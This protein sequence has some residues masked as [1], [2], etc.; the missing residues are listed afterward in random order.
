MV[1]DMYPGYDGPRPKM[2]IYHG[3]ADTTLHANN[4]E[5]TIKQWAGVFGYDYT[6]PE[7]TQANTPQSRYTTYTWGGG[8]LVGVYA[9]GVGHSVPMRGGDDMKF[10]EL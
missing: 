4:Y 3:S 7:T 1:H 8:Q 5:E 9:Q 6:R 10:F 2:Q